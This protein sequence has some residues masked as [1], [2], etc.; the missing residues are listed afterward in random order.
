ML[1]SRKIRYTY[2]FPFLW[3]FVINIFLIIYASCIGV[4]F[5]HKQHLNFYP[6]MCL[7]LSSNGVLVNVLTTG[8]QKNRQEWQ[9][10]W[11][12]KCIDSHGVNIPTMV[13]F[14]LLKQPHQIQCYKE[15]CFVR[16]CKSVGA[17]SC[18]PPQKVLICKQEK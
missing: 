18:T 17:G 2:S 7:C 16:S 11:F 3:S 9:K 15:V 10:L 5:I 13:D 14:K 1:L 8:F 4:L 6:W 12:V